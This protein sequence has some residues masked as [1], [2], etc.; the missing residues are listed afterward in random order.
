[1]H[2]ISATSGNKMFALIIKT[3]KWRKI[4]FLPCFL[5]EYVGTNLKGEQIYTRWFY[6][7]DV[8]DD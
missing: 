5:V 2:V 6:P 4:L 1:M 3:S 8:H 7:S